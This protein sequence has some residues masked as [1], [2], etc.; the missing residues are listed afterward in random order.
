[1][2]SSVVEAVEAAEA[3]CRASPGRAAYILAT[4]SFRLLGSLLAVMEGDVIAT[5]PS[6]D[7][8]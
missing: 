6:T 8:S 7:L 4:G 5:E 3:I 2:A 1:V